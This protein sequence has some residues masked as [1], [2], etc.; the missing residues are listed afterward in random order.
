MNETKKILTIQDISCYGQCSITVALP[1]I[2][3]FGIETAV[4]PSA[5]LSTHTGGFKNFT[6]RDLSEDIPKI[7]GHWKE[8][9]I[10][11]DAI[12][13]G[14]L[15]SFEQIDQMKAFIDAKHEKTLAVVDPAMADNGKLYKGFTLE[16]AAAMAKLCAKADYIIPNITEA[17]FLTDMEYKEEYNKEYFPWWSDCGHAHVLRHESCT[18]HCNRL[19]RGR[20]CAQERE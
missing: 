10:D 13:T 18:D 5:V 7:I 9:N 19:R 6:F 4:L 20:A 1:I 17:A 8:E 14:Y 2:S 16:F 3:A 11:F 12:Y 15:G